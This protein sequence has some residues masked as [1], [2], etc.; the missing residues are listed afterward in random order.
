[1][2][3]NSEVMRKVL[4]TL[5]NISGRKTT[6]GHAVF[7]MDSLIKKLEGNH[8]ILKHVKVADTRFLEDS[9]FITV[10]SD[11]DSVSSTEVGKAIYAIIVSMDEMLGRD[12][13][14]F[15][16]KEISRNIGDEYYSTISE[17]G[18]DLS[19]MQLEHEVKEMEKRILHTKKTE[20]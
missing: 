13:G 5:I 11:L 3:K 8:D 19:L 2:I 18:V 4:T 16:M 20:E 15:F 14:H 9:V 6:E 17:M 1:M 12:A 7:V 10:M